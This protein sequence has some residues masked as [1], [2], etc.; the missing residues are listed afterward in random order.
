MLKNLLNKSKQR[1][2]GT[3]ISLAMA[4]SLMCGCGIETGNNPPEEPTEYGVEIGDT[5]ENFK[6][7]KCI[8][9]GDVPQGED[10]FLYNQHAK[11]IWFTIHSGTCHYC[12]VQSAY[13]EETDVY[14]RYIEKGL[15]IIMAFSGDENGNFK[16]ENL[17]EYCCDYKER[18]NFTFPLV[19]AGT[20][21]TKK[22]VWG[23]PLNMLI[24]DEMTIGYKTNRFDP[25]LIEIQLDLLLEK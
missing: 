17:L 1:I 5:I 2:V 24:D 3:A 20:E 18:H 12:H 19:I 11:V 23:L 25:E 13:M 16:R 10:L 8:C 4:A 7:E 14:G 21:I 15:E 6:V 9:S 22:Y